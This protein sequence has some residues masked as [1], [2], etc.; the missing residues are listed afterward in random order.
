MDAVNQRELQLKQK[1]GSGILVAL[2]AVVPDS[3]DHRLH[4]LRV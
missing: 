2:N 4:G 3:A 1:E